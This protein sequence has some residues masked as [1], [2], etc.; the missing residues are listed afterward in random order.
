MEARLGLRAA[1]RA[2]R[3]AWGST[4][5]PHGNLELRAAALLPPVEGRV[6]QVAHALD[7]LRTSGEVVLLQRV[8]LEIEEPLLAG[9]RAEFRGEARSGGELLARDVLQEEDVL[10]ALVAHVQRVGRERGIAPVGGAA[11]ELA[12]LVGLALEQRAQAPAAASS[13]QRG[14]GVVEDG[15]VHVDEIDERRETAAR[16]RPRRLDDQRGAHALLHR[17]ALGPRRRRPAVVC[18]EDDQRRLELTQILQLL[19]QPAVLGVQPRLHR[20]AGA[21]GLHVGVRVA[22]VARGDLDRG[23]REG[24]AEARRRPV[25]RVRQARSPPDEPRT[26][27]RVLVEE[28]EAV[29]HAIALARE[30]LVVLGRRVEAEPGEVPLPELA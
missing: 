4:R 16:R 8:L 17:R 22:L 30:L 28:A 10:P 9:A 18:E 29:L 14:A 1:A 19:D 2:R 26:L 20:E 24:L 11:Q 3:Q 5:R 6:V 13:W 15:G 21:L 12:R 23:V 25:R 27:G 7:L